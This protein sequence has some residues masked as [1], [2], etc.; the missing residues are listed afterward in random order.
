MLFL[1]FA[2]QA[3]ILTGETH[4]HVQDLLLLDV[5]PLRCGRTMLLIKR[6][7]NG[8]WGRWMLAVLLDV[9]ALCQVLL[10]VIIGSPCS[11][12]TRPC[13]PPPHSL[14]PCSLCC[15]LGLETAG[16]VMTVLIPRNTTVP[17]KKEQV[18]STY[19][20]N[21]P[22]VLI[23]VRCGTSWHAE[24]MG[25]GWLLNAA[26]ALWTNQPRLVHTWASALV[27]ANPTQPNPPSSHHHQPTYI[28]SL[29]LS[30]PPQVYEGERAQTRHNNLLGKFELTGIP[31]APRGIPQINVAFDIDANGACSWA[32]IMH[33]SVPP[34]C[35]C[36]ASGGQELPCACAAC[37]PALVPS[38]PLR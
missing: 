7:G 9:T 26:V 5:T 15:S 17:T 4:E 34:V 35:T 28:P 6:L 19:S 37:L 1:L 23:Q 31:P 36:A 10:G 3:A 32:W 24:R 14:P 22:A 25:C 11:L 33:L 2:L 18:F 16:G 38:Y 12:P 8:H 30:P 13:A 29:P 27:P 20:D 21:Q